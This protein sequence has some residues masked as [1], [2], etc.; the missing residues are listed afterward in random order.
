MPSSEKSRPSSI[1][2]RRDDDDPPLAKAWWFHNS[3]LALDD[4]LASLPKAALD[5]GT[6]KPFSQRDCVALEEQWEKLP[7]RIKRQEEHVPDE[8]GVVDELGNQF[9]RVM[10]EVKEREEVDDVSQDDTKVIVGV[11]RLH[12]VDVTTLKF[13]IWRSC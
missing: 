1:S 2:S 4:P 11:E 9:K 5:E 10:T 3:A 13:I 7:E 12:H 6:W 8:N